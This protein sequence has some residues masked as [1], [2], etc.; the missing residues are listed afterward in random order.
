MSNNNYYFISFIFILFLFSA[1]S[2][3]A[4]SDNGKKEENEPVL[5]TVSDQ[6]ETKDAKI[7]VAAERTDEYLHLLEGKKVALTVN[8]TSF[9]GDIHL[10]DFLISKGVDVKR[11]YAP[12]H[13]FRGQA[14]AGATVKNGRDEKTGLPIISLYG[15]RKK[16]LPEDVEGIDFIIFDIQDVGARFY[17]Y[18][19]TMHYVMEAAAENN[20]PVL[21]L[22]RPNPNGHYIDGPILEDDFRS[23]VG[24]HKIPVVHGLT[25]AEL[26]Q[27]INGEKWL[28][29]GVQCDLHFVKCENYTHNS[30]YVLPIK[31]SP[32]LPNMHSIYLYPSLCFFEGTDVNAGRG[33]EKQFQVYGHPSYPEK[34]F[35]YTPISRPGAKYPKHQNK[36]CFG[37]DLS[38]EALHTL[39]EQKKINLDYL[40]QFYHKFPNKNSFFLKNNFMDKLAGTDALR[41][42]I[43][44][45]KSEAEIRRSWKRGI[46]EYKL[47]REKYLLYAD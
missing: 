9:V 28:K 10:V 17:T 47:M 13:G 4:T 23:F 8:H 11:I 14:D 33:T 26:A 34:T 30:S 35:S 16:P 18:I 41:K 46:D 31:P 32:N 43:L 38:G 21:I 39:R 42:D 6:F 44:A 36:E 7:R 25:V 12:E 19:S 27:M 15:K 37:V 3:K 22:D 1:C 45:G 2:N 20:I 29:N 40:I 24:M 5:Q